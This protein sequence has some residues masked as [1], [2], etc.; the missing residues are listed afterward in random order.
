M[1]KVI[2]VLLVCS[3]I[4]L[5]T[6]S[7]L[8][9]DSV[10]ESKSYDLDELFNDYD[11]KSLSEMVEF[12]AENQSVFCFVEHFRYQRLISQLVSYH[13][14]VIHVSGEY[15]HPGEIHSVFGTNFNA[16]ANISKYLG[17]GDRPV[18]PDS[19]PLLGEKGIKNFTIE[20]NEEFIDHINSLNRLD[21]N[22]L[23]L[24][25][26]MNL[27]SCEDV[28][29]IS[30]LDH[31]RYGSSAPGINTYIPYEPSILGD[32]TADGVVNSTDAYVMKKAIVG[33][34]NGIDPFAVDLNVDGSIS[35]KD[36]LALR[37]KIV[38]E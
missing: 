12:I 9:T 15:N 26:I 34:T 1:K 32:C 13:K 23:I 4:L 7:V 6:V 35:A 14:L 36:S 24:D 19:S 2:S 27:M 22:I 33:Y 37:K 28:V 16:N 17:W 10:A 18:T 11:E 8:A 3:M 38:I 5:S 21:G 29:G 25:F 20:M 30:I 31:P